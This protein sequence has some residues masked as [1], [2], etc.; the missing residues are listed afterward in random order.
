MSHLT[1]DNVLIISSMV[2]NLTHADV[3]STR[4]DADL[5]ADSAPYGIRAHSDVDRK[6]DR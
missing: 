4:A 1:V 2:R 5:K 6:L 3:K